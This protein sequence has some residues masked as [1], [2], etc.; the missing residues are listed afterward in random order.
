M[1]GQTHHIDELGNG[2]PKAHDHHVRGVGHRSRPAVVAPKEVFEEAVLSVGVGGP[3]RGY[4]WTGKEMGVSRCPWCWVLGSLS[5]P[6]RATQP[7]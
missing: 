7:H 6:T 4:C 3:L 5:C 1:V 2:Q